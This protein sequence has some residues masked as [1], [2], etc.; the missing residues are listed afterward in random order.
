M[1]SACWDSA[2]GSRL[3]EMGRRQKG[4]GGQRGGRRAF[5]RPVRIQQ[6]KRLLP[7][8]LTVVSKARLV[9]C[10]HGGRARPTHCR[11]NGAANNRGADPL[12][13]PAHAVR[14]K[15]NMKMAKVTKREADCS[16]AAATAIATAAAVEDRTL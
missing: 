5:I 6:H 8:R 4:G 11:P 16:P 2:Q 7:W 10:W 14:E 13:P 3:A 9:E 15:P 1:P 12:L